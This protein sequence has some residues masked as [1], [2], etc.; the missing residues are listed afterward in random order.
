MSEEP[1]ASVEAG[2]PSSAGTLG[3]P[4]AVALIMGSIVGTGIFTLPSTV[5]QYGMV[6]LVGFVFAAVGAIALA[7]IFAVVPT[8]PRAGWSARLR[9]R[10]LRLR[11]R[12]R[13]RADSASLEGAGVAGPR[14]PQG[15]LSPRGG[16]E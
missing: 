8:Y 12:G 9:A 2:A 11:A 7:L 13:R 15:G 14:E 3:L 16:N 5:A 4:A 1:T 10:G 6:G